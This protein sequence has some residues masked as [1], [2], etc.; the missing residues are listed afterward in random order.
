MP[1]VDVNT[2]DFAGF[3][4]LIGAAFGGNIAGGQTAARKRRQRQRR[5]R[6]WIVSEGEGRNDCAGQLDAAAGGCDARIA[7]DDQRAARRRRRRQ[8]ERRAGH[9]AADARRRHRSSEPRRHPRAHQSQGRR[10]R[11]EAWPGRRRSIGRAKSAIPRSFRRSSAPV[12]WRA[13]C[14]GRRAR[15]FAPATR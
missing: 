7:G 8:R 5:V 6:R 10:Q 11:A 13:R 2:A 4:P 1:G 3:T 14:A 9:D 15:A 12:P